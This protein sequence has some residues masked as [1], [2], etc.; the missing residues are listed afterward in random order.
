MPLI[1]HTYTRSWCVSMVGVALFLFATES[2]GEE[3]DEWMKTHGF[4]RSKNSLRVTRVM[5]F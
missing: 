5:I 2:R 3:R 1:N 4:F